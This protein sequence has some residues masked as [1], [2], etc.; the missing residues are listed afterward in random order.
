MIT[1]HEHIG[2]HQLIYGGAKL[3][4]EHL[5]SLIITKTNVHLGNVITLFAMVFHVVEKPCAMNPNL[6][7]MIKINKLNEGMNKSL[8]VQ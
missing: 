5:P 3:P 7:L 8:Q 4:S 2:T 6:I 1:C